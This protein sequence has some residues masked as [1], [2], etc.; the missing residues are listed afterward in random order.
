MSQKLTTAI[1][2]YTHWLR[3]YS[4]PLW[5]TQGI[6]K[7]GAS[8]EQLLA[9]GAPDLACNK[10]VRV[11][12]RQ[13]FV[14]AAAHQEGWIDNG[15][16]LVANLDKFVSKHAA[17]TNQALYAHLLDCDN[18]IIDAHFDL[19]DIA[20]FLL[21]FAWRYQ[22]FNDL[23][24]LAKANQV[25][26]QIDKH[27]KDFPGGWK[28][29][30]YQS[31]YRRQNPHMHLFEAFLTLYQVSK[32]G[33]W[34]AKAGE[35]YC[36]FETRF[37]AQKHGV[38]LEFFTDNW[39]P[40][41][42]DKG[43]II[44][45]GHMLEWVW[46]LRQYQ[47]YTGA[48][49]DGY[50]NILYKNALTLGL[51]ENKNLLFD[52]VDLNGKPLKPTKRCWPMTEWIKASLAQ[53]EATAQPSY[54]DDAE[55]ALNSLMQHFCMDGLHGQHI[56]QLNLSNKVIVDKAPASTLYH[57]ILAG[58]EAQKFKQKNVAIFKVA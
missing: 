3:N 25:L 30:D 49:V 24:A 34:L 12:A 7:L 40:L 19:Y 39:E 17:V 27:L 36:L 16:E 58:L 38:L 22:V 46:L 45:P 52:E 57:L 35:I 6:D 51:D 21:A 11:Q 55:K 9:S 44:E 41:S 32:D 28:E 43:K 2:K 31:D 29:G 1:D 42:N 15:M 26:S 37:F 33:K 8:Y 50:C 47:K 13:M 14:F 5:T 20:F 53:A 54:I 4:L 48:P 10:R 56:D 23:N 18:N